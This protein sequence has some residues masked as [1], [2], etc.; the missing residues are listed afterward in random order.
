MLLVCYSVCMLCL[1]TM[2]RVRVLT[3]LCGC[4]GAGA[5]GSCLGTVTN[6]FVGCKL[7]FVGFLLSLGCYLFCLNFNFC[8][9]QVLLLELK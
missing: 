9:F 1:S 8:G 7:C 4:A 6:S 5:P 3:V 2:L